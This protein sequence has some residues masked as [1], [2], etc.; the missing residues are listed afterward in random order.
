MIPSL[1]IGLIWLLFLVNKLFLENKLNGIDVIMLSKPVSKYETF[2][3]RIIIIFSFLFLIM[4]AQFILSSILVFSFQHDVKWITYLLINNLFITPFIFSAIAA[5][6]ILLAIIFKSLWFGLVSF[7]IILLVGIVPIVP[8]LIDKNNFDT[9]LTYNNNNYNSFS[10]LTIINDDKN[11]TFLVDEI[12]VASQINVDKNIITT[13]NNSPFYNSLIPGELMLSL[14][15]SLIDNLNFDTNQINGNYS[16][17]KN[18]FI[19]TQLANL[20]I[21]NSVLMSIRPNDV[22]PF[23]LNSIQYEELLLENIKKIV[24]NSTDFINLKDEKIVDF[25]YDKLDNSLS[26]SID[27]LS[28]YEF[29]TVKALLGIDI[30]FS[31]LFYYFNNKTI[32]EQ[33]TPNLLKRIE[34]ELSPSLSK[35]LYFL[36]SDNSSIMNIFD[37]KSFGDVFEIFPNTKIKSLT[38]LP[39]IND[40]NFIKNDLIRFSGSTIHY[41][42]ANKQYIPT[43]LLE[44]QKIDSSII[45]KQTWNKFVDNSSVS[46][47]SVIQLSILLNNNL[48][49]IFQ[50][51]FENN[52]EDLFKYSHFIKVKTKT[53]LDNI[54]LPIMTIVFLTIGSNILAIYMFKNKNYKN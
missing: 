1:I 17:L 30:E 37:L 4:F 40:I 13:L 28:K 11:E 8:R 27:S 43:T 16:L 45:D 12:N 47:Q 29:L 33:K 31:Q 46:L 2:F 6:L 52:T 23:E 19:D 24:N 35:L 25:L 54:S 14:S 10:K 41:L 38:E 3:S 50:V 26:W 39:N 9:T 36:W 53:Y 18:E 20:N 7:V 42:D 15:S 49:N 21:K 34:L 22:S 5:I 32:L 48:N 51:R 44:M